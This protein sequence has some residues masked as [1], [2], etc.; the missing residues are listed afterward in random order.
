MGL[1]DQF[2]VILKLVGKL[3]ELYELPSSLLSIRSTF[4][5]CKVSVR[6]FKEFFLPFAHF[7]NYRIPYQ[8]ETVPEVFP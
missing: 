4:L 3:P 1:L 7:F 5:H 8:F 6:P 2:C